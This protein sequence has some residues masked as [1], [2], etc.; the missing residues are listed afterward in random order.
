MQKFLKEL[1][2]SD[3]AKH[4]TIPEH[5]IAMYFIDFDAICDWF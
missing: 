1:F 2:F 5:E 3:D 4:Y